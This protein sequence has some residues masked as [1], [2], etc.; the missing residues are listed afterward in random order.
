MAAPAS[1]LVLLTRLFTR[2]IMLEVA[3]V[4]TQEVVALLVLLLLMVLQPGALQVGELPRAAAAGAEAPAPRRA[5]LPTSA[6]EALLS[7][8]EAARPAPEL[9]LQESMEWTSARLG[10]RRRSL[11]TPRAP[12]RPASARASPPSAISW[13]RRTAAAGRGAGRELPLLLVPPQWQL[14]E[15][16]PSAREEVRILTAVPRP[17]ARPLASLARM[18]SGAQRARGAA[19]VVI[20]PS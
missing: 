5:L 8:R 2:V 13:T 12:W 16:G 6:A 11:W 14:L 15:F 17:A 4:A 10:A 9:N 18:S 7:G 3:R 19:A 1:L 20:A